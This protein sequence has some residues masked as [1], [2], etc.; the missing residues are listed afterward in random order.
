MGM[1]HKQI[2]AVLSATVD[3]GM[4]PLCRLKLDTD[5]GGPRRL[6]LFCTKEA[7]NETK[8][9]WVDALILLGNRIKVLLEIEETLK[10]NIRS[11][12]IWLDLATFTF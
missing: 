11:A 2:G 4:L 6:Q 8:Y 12:P 5:C 3:S 7:K 1:F 9:C 10:S